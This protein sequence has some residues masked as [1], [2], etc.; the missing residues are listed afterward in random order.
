MYYL[1]A[2]LVVMGGK[3]IIMVHSESIHTSFPTFCYS[4]NLKLI[5]YSFFCHWPTHNTL[6]SKTQSWTL[7]LTVVSALCDSLLSPPSCPLCCCLC[8][9]MFVPCFVLLPSYVATMPCCHVLMP[10]YGV[11]LGLSLCSDVCF[12]LYLSQTPVPAGGL[13]VG[14][15]YK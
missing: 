13:L 10:C 15:H 5:K 1:L 7:L 11:V 4:L 2:Y 3:S 6:H 9:I 8:P 12:V 14:W